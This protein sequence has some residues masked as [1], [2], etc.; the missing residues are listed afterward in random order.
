[1]DYRPLFA[2][3]CTAFLVV[4]SAAV[5]AGKTIDEAG[6]IVCATD[7]WDEKEVE[8]GHK[9]VDSTSR[10]VLLSDNAKDDKVSEA[11]AGKYEYMPDGSWKGNGTCTDTHPGGDKLFLTWTEGSDLKE[12]TYQKTGGTGKFQG[13]T[14]EGT[15]KYD[16]LTD[17]LFAGRFKGKYVLP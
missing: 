14:G 15:Y 12:Y 5:Q 6:I 8:K 4:G 13:A 7:K 9:L 10:C 11:C 17:T 1:M 2:M 3:T 16:G